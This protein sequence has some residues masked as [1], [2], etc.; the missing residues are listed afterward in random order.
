MWRSRRTDAYEEL[1]LLAA[2]GRL[3]VASAPDR[4][5]R[6]DL[7][8]TAEAGYGPQVCLGRAWFAA[9]LA[10]EP[11]PIVSPDVSPDTVGR[12]LMSSGTTQAP[13]RVGLTWRMV[14]ANIRNASITLYAGK[15]GCWMPLTGLDSMAGLL[16]V[17][18]AWALGATVVVGHGG[19]RLVETLE[20]LRPSLIVFTP[21]HLRTLLR[22]LP[23]G[24][25]PQ[26][27]LRLIVGGSIL[28]QALAQEARLRLT[29][30]LRIV[31]WLDRVQRHGAR[32]RR[33]ARHH[34]L[35]HRLSGPRRAGGYSRCRW[36]PGGGR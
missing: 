26:P 3:R 13:R 27:D 15:L 20:R 5:P 34:S 24:F 28:P 10:A 35:R 21:S 4:D 17:S 33:P 6:A 18:G 19:E 14:D 22:Q 8:L 30:D 12:V 16:L 36:R 1:L 32:G 9:T 7:W 11:R 29:P 2:L 23:P 25:R 31:Y